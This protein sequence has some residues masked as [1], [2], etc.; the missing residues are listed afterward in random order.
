MSKKEQTYQIINTDERAPRAI[1]VGLCTTQSEYRFERAMDELEELAE[2]CGIET[3]LIETQNADRPVQSTYIGSGKVAEVK[4]DIERKEAD[5]VIFDQMLSPSQFRNLAKELGVEVMDRTGLILRIFSEQAR[6]RE[7]RLQVEHAQ[8]QY[9]MPRLAGMWTHFG[10]QSGASG[11]MSNRGVGETQL[12]LDRR[13]I[14]RRMAELEKELKA[15]S[16]ERVTQREKRLSSG[17]PRVALVGYTNAGK[18]TLMNRLLDRNENVSEDKKVYEKDKL[19]ATLDTTVRKIAPKGMS[20]FL[21]S[22]T[23]GFINELP[24]SLVKAFRSTLEEVTYADLLLQVVDFSDPDYRECMR[25][26]ED[27]LR[28]IGAGGIPMIYI[29]NK[30]DLVRG[31]DDF[32]ADLPLPLV[33][34]DCMYMCAADSIGITE[35][36][37]LIE[38]T[39]QKDFVAVTLQLPFSGSEIVGRLKENAQLLSMEY[40]AEGIAVTAR[41]GSEDLRRYA[42]YIKA[43]N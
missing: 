27:T 32:P 28:D 38:R 17:L 13:H 3:V 25:V 21:L 12:E 42:G 2:A 22:D 34:E 14:E 16:R 4:E 8:L 20:P 26:T 9:T 10:R 37:E 33:K 31:S 1:L 35:L 11:S 15:I 24:H 43:G 39:L 40:S 30:V 23:V 41:L 5:L 36:L 6:T 18:S 7:A 19:F 29:Y